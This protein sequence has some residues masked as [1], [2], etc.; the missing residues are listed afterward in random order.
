MCGG[1]EHLVNDSNEDRLEDGQK[2]ESQRNQFLH[3][4]V[5]AWKWYCRGRWKDLTAFMKNNSKWII[6]RNIKCKVCKTSTR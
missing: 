5:M 3:R 1:T 4:E 6:D 2:T